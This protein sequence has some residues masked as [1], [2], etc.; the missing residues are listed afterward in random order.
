[1]PKTLNASSFVIS[2]FSAPE[3]AGIWSIGTRAELRIPVDQSG[4]YVFE[5]LPFLVKEKLTRQRF[6]FRTADR[7]LYSGEAHQ[8]AWRS[9]SAW[10]D[11]NEADRDGFVHLVIETP[12]ATAPAD[13]GVNRD[14]RRLALMFRNIFVYPGRKFTF[15]HGRTVGGESSKSYDNKIVSGFWNK[16]IGGP[17]V[18]DIGFRGYTAGVEPIVA[19]AIGVDLDYPGY[20]GKRLPFPDESQDAVYSSHCLEHMADPLNAFR[21]W[22]RV[23]KYGGHFIVVVPHTFL[24]ERRF[25]PP[26]RWSHEH[27]RFYTPAALLRELESALR[28][29]TYR[30][31]HLADNDLGYDYKLAPEVHPNGCYEIELVVQKRPAPHWQLEDL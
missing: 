9:T 24:Y 2:G 4:S 27:L 11:K 17:N 18:L 19:G 14:P 25:R 30:V 31:R 3:A 5:R 23:L 8:H 29:N 1:M 7:I 26:S 6:T 28:P 16:Y 22:W 20:D 12:D 21:E 13:L 10:I 15:E